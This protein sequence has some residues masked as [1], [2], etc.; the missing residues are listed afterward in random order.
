MNPIVIPALAD[1]LVLPH[2]HQ[3]RL[4]VFHLRFRVNPLFDNVLLRNLNL[5]DTLLFLLFFHNCLSLADVQ[6]SHE[7]ELL[8]TQKIKTD[9]SCGDGVAADVMELS[10]AIEYFADVAVRLLHYS[11]LQLRL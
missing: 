11:L 7:H 8:A 10:Q 9:C 1:F 5:E 4:E 3:M 6:K 2:R